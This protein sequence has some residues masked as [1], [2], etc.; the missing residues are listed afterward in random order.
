[1]VIATD[2]FIRPARAQAKNL[3]MPDLNVVVVEQQRPWHTDEMR[4]VEVAKIITD[5]AS[6][7]ANEV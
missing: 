2:R 7:L 4:E 1:M 3:Q 6:G 5:V